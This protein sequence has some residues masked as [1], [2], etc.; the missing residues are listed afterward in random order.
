MAVSPFFVDS[1]TL[2]QKF[3]H[4]FVLQRRG[5]EGYQP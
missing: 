2:Q 3:L 5:N 4:E 1:D